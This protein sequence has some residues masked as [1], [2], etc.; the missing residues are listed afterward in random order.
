MRTLLPIIA[1]FLLVLRVDARARALALAQSVGSG[2]LSSATT[3]AP[4]KATVQQ[5]RHE[6]ENGAGYGA[7]RVV[8]RW[9]LMFVA[10][11]GGGG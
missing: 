2:A 3:N 4:G 6:A 7:G 5:Q 8:I 10:G 11:V 1:V 9:G